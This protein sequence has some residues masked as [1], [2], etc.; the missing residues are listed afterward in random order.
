KAEVRE[1]DAKLALLKAGPR[2]EEVFEK[3]QHVARLKAFYERS[4]EDLER[5]RQ[6]L[7]ADLTKFDQQIQQTTTE[8][9]FAQGFLDRAKRLLDKEALAKEKYRE[10]EKT[11]LVTLAMLEQVQAQKRSREVEGTLCDEKELAKC[12]KELGDAESELNVLIAPPRP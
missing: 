11:A 4:Q 6:A 3:R 5:K 7:Q 8:V 2:K 9:R 1:A 10:A 12:A